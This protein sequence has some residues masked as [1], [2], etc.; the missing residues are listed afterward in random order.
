MKI[1]VEEVKQDLKDIKHF[2]AH[3]ELFK[4]AL[5]IL[6]LYGNIII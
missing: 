5:K 4:K 3:E 1:T 2:Y 6:L